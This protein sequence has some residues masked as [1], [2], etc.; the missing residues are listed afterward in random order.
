[1]IIDFK[2]LLKIEDKN[3]LDDKTKLQIKKMIF[4]EKL[5]LE[6]VLV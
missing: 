3:K 4:L 1:M 6:T 2:F 5:A